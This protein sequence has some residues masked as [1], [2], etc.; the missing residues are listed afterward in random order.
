VDVGELLTGIDTEFQGQLRGKRTVLRT[1]PGSESIVAFADRKRVYQV[2]NNLVSNAVKFTPRGTVRLAARRDGDVVRVSVADDGPGI[3][4]A[5][6]DTIFSEFQQSGTSSMKSRGTG[7]GLAICKKLVELQG[8]T[9]GVESVVG[10]GSTF[11][12]TLP[13][14][15]PTGPEGDGP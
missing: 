13:V 1:D 3:P 15:E 4:A 8:G 6:L 12:F 7:L 2:V 11:S 10:E 9:I 5:D 14:H